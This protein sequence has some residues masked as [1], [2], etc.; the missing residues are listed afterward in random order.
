MKMNQIISSGGLNMINTA[1]QSESINKKA[2]CEK[3][4]AALTDFN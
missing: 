2:R 4:K 1:Y 3:L